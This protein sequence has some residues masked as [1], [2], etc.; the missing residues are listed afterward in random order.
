MRWGGRL[1][2]GP[3]AWRAWRAWDPQRGP[4]RR[5]RTTGTSSKGVGVLRAR[6]ALRAQNSQDRSDLSLKDAL[7]LLLG[8][9]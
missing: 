8:S 1:G 5:P 3:S 7:E 6:E 9:T 2:P 4:A